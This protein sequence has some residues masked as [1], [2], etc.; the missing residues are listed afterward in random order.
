MEMQLTMS[1]VNKIK[2]KEQKKAVN[3]WAKNNFKGSI[4]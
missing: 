1:E 3:N 2:D 4:F